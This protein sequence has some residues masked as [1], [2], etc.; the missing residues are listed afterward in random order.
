M[1]V[2]LKRYALYFLIDVSLKTLTMKEHWIYFVLIFS[3]PI[4]NRRVFYIV[5]LDETVWFRGWNRSYYVKDRS[6]TNHDLS[7]LRVFKQN[8]GHPHDPIHL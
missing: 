3:I 1:T 2:N 8:S 6:A 5:V 4:L 7:K